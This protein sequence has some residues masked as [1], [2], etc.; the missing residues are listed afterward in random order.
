MYNTENIVGKV[1]VFGC[2]EVS[3]YSMGAG[4]LSCAASVVYGYP[5]EK[6]VLQE[7]AEKKTAVKSSEKFYDL[8]SCLTVYYPVLQDQN[9]VG[10]I[11][12]IYPETNVTNEIMQELVHII[13]NVFVFLLVMI[14]F[15]TIVCFLLLRPLNKIKHALSD[16]SVGIDL[17][18]PPKEGNGTEMRE[19]TNLFYHMTINIR[20]H[21]QHID[22][23]ERAYEPY[24]PQSLISLFEKKDIREISPADETVMMD[25]AIL[26]IDAQD[27]AE[28]VSKAGTQEMFQFVNSVLQ[29][30]TAS[31]ENTGGT[32]IQF[33][34]TGLIAF[35]ENNPDQASQAAITAQKALQ[36]IS[37]TMAGENISF[38][39]GI[40]CGDLHIGIIGDEERMEIRAVSPEMT[41]AQSLQKISSI[42]H[43]GILI[44]GDTLE[45]LDLTMENIRLFGYVDDAEKQIY[46]VFE[47]QKSDIVMLKSITKADFEAGDYSLAKDCFI[48]VLRKNK[49]DLAA[50][51]YL[52][53]CGEPAEVK[54]KGRNLFE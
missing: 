40:V 44:D 19:I 12:V 50:G 29:E 16:F 4:S 5:T 11:R 43:L 38:G 39:T 45:R 36:T 26:I 51:R 10:I 6:A 30:L 47:G 15:L 37:L 9:I 1:S 52:V 18:E 23:L 41:F 8:G 14:G 35:F 3:F 32:V 54:E 2:S 49:D 33:T 22:Q 21:L 27:F 34:D 46:E 20:E 25:A 48:R 17:D 28:A 24:I 42:Y 53:L 31:V 7:I 13:Q